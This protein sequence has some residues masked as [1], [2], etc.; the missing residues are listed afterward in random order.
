MRT[1]RVPPQGR[2]SHEGSATTPQS[3]LAAPQAVREMGWTSLFTRMLLPAMLFGVSLLG[4]APVTAKAQALDARATTAALVSTDLQAGVAAAR[5]PK[6]NWARDIQGVRHV[7]VIV[8]SNTTDPQMTD[9]RNF[10]R[11]NGGSILARQLAVAG[12]ER[13]LAA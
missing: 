13:L 8:V 5:T 10:I 4:I 7:Q 3:P 1:Y 9:L 6:V 2:P 11:R 12:R